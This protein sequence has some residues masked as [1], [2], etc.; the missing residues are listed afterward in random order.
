MK[1]QRHRH[2]R[3]VAQ[4]HTVSEAAGLEVRS[5][6][7]PG[8]RFL[9]RAVEECRAGDPDRDGGGRVALGAMDRTAGLVLDPQT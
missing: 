4:G 3:S 6:L 8:S 2:V 9:A 1:K 5:V 7:A